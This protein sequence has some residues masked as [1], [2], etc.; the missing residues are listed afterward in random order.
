MK[1]LFLTT[2]LARKKQLGG[3][4]STQAFIDALTKSGHE[5]SVL[6]YSR[7]DDLSFEK[8]PQEIVIGQRYIES[9]RTKLYSTIWL[10]SSLLK[11]LPYS[12]GKYYS[13]AYINTVKEKLSKE[14]YDVVIIDH[15][16]LE[17]LN[18]F[19]ESKY[20]TALI[21]HN[22]EHEIY[23]ESSKSAGNLVSSWIYR[24]EARLVKDMED[25]LAASLNELWAY[26]PHDAKYFSS[27]ENVG[28]VRVFGIPPGL[29]KLKPIAS[30]SK[31]CDI[32]ILGSWSWRANE[33]GLQWFLQLVYPHLPSSLSIH[34]AGKGG[35]WLVGKY[36]NINYRGYVP[37]AQEFMAQAKV[38]AIPILSGSGIQIKTLDAIASGSSIVATPIALRGISDPPSTVKIAENP[39]DFANL[40]VSAVNSPATQQASEEALTWAQTRQD[41]FIADVA[42][43]I[44]EM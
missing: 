24:R 41:N 37:D 39:E 7:K 14:N 5:V 33:E 12:A 11:N 38:M 20:K 35:D 30:V 32:G 18:H 8:S 42:R 26:T 15:S 40:L 21:A 44:N 19:I 16:R 34:I 27:L 13:R 17:W 31:Q 4:I 43:A 22:I 3:E 25:R 10:I 1:I 29:D 6:G 9:K 23:L 36:P 2:I 28:K